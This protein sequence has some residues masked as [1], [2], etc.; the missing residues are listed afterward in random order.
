MD[1]HIGKV[2]NGTEFN[3]IFNDI[4]FVKLTNEAENH[5][6]FQFKDG[7]NIDTKDFR[8]DIICDYGL[9]FTDYDN[10]HRWIDYGYY[11]MRYIR[12]VTIPNDARVCIENNGKYKTDKFILSSREAIENEIYLKV[13][14][15]NSDIIISM[16]DFLK[17]KEIC[18]E[19]IKQDINML[20]YIPEYL[21]NKE[22][23]LE[24]V[25]QYGNKLRDV[26]KHLSDGEICLEAVKENGCALQYVSESLQNYT[27]CIQE[28]I[29]Q[30]GY[31]LQYVPDAFKDYKICLKAV[32]QNGYALYYVPNALKDYRLCLEAV[33]YNANILS[34]D[35][36]LAKKS[37]NNDIPSP[38]EYV[39]GYLK[40]K[41]LCLL[42]VKQNKYA[43]KF[44]PEH[45]QELCEN[46]IKN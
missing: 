38:I 3:H 42:A 22:I 40:D 7:L 35:R 11:I 2:L 5:N 12:K 29:K 28:A 39:P 20:E 21:K 14:K 6:E 24:I 34:K 19:A 36:L 30:N 26:P 9:Y 33:K 25:K 23:Y 41:E 4:V 44:V 17:T 16:P 15:T 43:I 37:L 46:I 32:K 45:L 18:L 10:M 31:A 27:L 1:A 13:V 8:T